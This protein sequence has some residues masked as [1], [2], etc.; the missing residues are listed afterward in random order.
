[1]PCFRQL[2]ERAQCLVEVADGFL[3]SR[4]RER[5]Q[6]SLVK[7]GHGPRPDLAAHRMMTQPFELLGNAARVKVFHGGHYLRMRG[8]PSLLEQAGVRNLMR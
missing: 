3:I 6:A 1:M 8:P 5:F 7:V 4:M 2:P